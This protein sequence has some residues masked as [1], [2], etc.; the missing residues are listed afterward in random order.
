MVRFYL[1]M[2]VISFTIAI[3]FAIQGAWLILPFAGLEMLLLGVALYLAAHK[4]ASWQQVVIRGDAIEISQRVAGRGQRHTLQRAW[5][6]VELK[7][8]PIKGHPS[9]LTIGSH[10]RSVEIGACLNETEKKQLARDLGFALD[11]HY[12]LV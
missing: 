9:R 7:P 4:G 1:G 3:A 2:V 10:G 12:Q 8:A 11:P 6:R 5:A